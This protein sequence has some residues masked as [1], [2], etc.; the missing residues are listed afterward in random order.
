MATEKFTKDINL[1]TYQIDGIN[2]ENFVEENGFFAYKR[3][4]ESDG[5]SISYRIGVHDSYIRKRYNFSSPKKVFSF[6]PA[7][8]RKF[9]VVFRVKTGKHSTSP[10]GERFY[11]YTDSNN[12]YFFSFKIKEIKEKAFDFTPKKTTS[13]VKKSKKGKKLTPEQAK[14][15]WLIN[16][17]FQG[18]G[19]SPR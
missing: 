4:F 12:Y 10:S 9:N 19:F 3:S 15:K 7:S 13:K 17:P 11:F 5:M 1:T 6:T 18:G 16:H 8:N 2:L 14:Q